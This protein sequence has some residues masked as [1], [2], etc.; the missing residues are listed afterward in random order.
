MI[1]AQSSIASVLIAV[2]VSE[3]K[4]I[5]FQFSM[6]FMEMRMGLAHSICLD[7][8]LVHILVSRS[9]QRSLDSFKLIWIIKSIENFD[10]FLSIFHAKTDEE[11]TKIRTLLNSTFYDKQWIKSLTNGWHSSQSRVPFSNLNK[12]HFATSTNENGKQNDNYFISIRL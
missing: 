10:E 11:K 9:V 12:L 1:V 6:L 5:S 3:M 4:F 8:F 2:I 7:T